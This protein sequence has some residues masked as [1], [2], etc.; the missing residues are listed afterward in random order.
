MPSRLVLTAV[1]LAT[2]TLFAC[3]ESSLTTTDAALVAEVPALLERSAP[4]RHGAEWDDVQRAYQRHRLAFEADPAA[5]LDALALVEL[6]VQEARVTGEHGHYY[7][8]ALALTDRVLALPD[9]TED[10]RFYALTLRSG[11]QLSQH[12][13][14][15]ALATGREAAALRPRDAQAQ[16]VLVDA[17]V[18]LGDYERAVAA[19]DAMVARRPDLRSYARISYLREIHGDVAGAKEAML[20]AARSAPPGSEEA[21]W[22]TLELA[23]L[24]DRHGD[25]ED[26][27]QVLGLILRDRPGYP[28]AQG[29]LAKMRLRDGEYAAANT[30][31][32]EAIAAIP[33]VGFYSTLARLHRA[34]GDREAYA[35][36]TR[37]IELMLA[38]DVASGHNMDL[39]YADYYLDL[40]D[41]P[42]TAL[43]YMLR[44]YE[45]RPDNIDV[46]RELARI[47]RALGD[48]AKVAEHRARAA[49]TNSRH[50]DLL[51]LAGAPAASSPQATA[52]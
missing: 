12:E 39:E 6:F 13:F 35:A 9:L 22:A 7:P 23:Q 3:R 14:A 26:A 32:D 2:A 40:R 21:A 28:F 47:Y 16:G 18:E 44:A 29:A 5:A 48:E 17:Y 20:M 30:L 49:R 42:E 31:L 10:H 36:T 25:R 46:N 51:E 50:P 15:E 19:S 52:G 11:V 27:E 37:E 8:A 33:E 45:A 4:T 24:L 38:D 34:T 41:D 1:A 43:T